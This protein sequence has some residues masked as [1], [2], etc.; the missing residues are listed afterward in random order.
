MTKN[1]VSELSADDRAWLLRAEEHILK[2]AR[3]KYSVGG[4]THG[5]DDLM[6]LQ[7]L[8]DDRVITA[9]DVLGAQCVGVALGNVFVA[10]LAM[11]WAR[12][13][14]EFGDMIALHDEVSGWTYY[15]LTMISKRFEDGR[16]VDLVALYRDLASTLR[17]NR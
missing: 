17:S 3:A 1:R 6:A 14:N 9:A 2:L 13:A 8:I 11:Q 4:F 12:V 16:G 7:R 15:P 5:E 10:Q